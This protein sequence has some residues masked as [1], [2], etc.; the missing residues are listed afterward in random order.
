LRPPRTALTPNLN[1]STFSSFAEIGAGQEV[2]RWFLVVGGASGIKEYPSRQK[3]ASF[4]IDDVLQMLKQ[5][6]HGSN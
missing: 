4:T 6:H 3:T 1:P 5:P 2:A